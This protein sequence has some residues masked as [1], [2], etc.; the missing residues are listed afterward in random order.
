MTSNIKTLLFTDKYKPKSYSDLLTDE[1]TNREILT[2]MKSWD[3]IV[4]N[5]KFQIPKIPITQ[6]LTQIRSQNKKNIKTQN[7]KIE[8]KNTI[9]QIIEYYEVEYV[10]SKHKII[11]ISGPPG[12][13]KTTIAN[14]ISRQC[15]Y[16]PIIIN[17]S[18][19]RTYDKLITRIYDTTL[20][21]N[22]NLSKKKNKPTCLI[23]D[24]I[25]GISS[26]FVGKNSIKNI[27]DFIK[28]GKLNK[29]IFGRHK[30][31]VLN[32]FDNKIIKV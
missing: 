24:E 6:N 2:W 18:D 12:I 31:E 9:N 10:Q 28:N 4:F 23:L 27:I 15:G 29:A 21:N 19:E 32:D 30:K 1:K 20:I 16:E 17:S 3:E 8:K 14:I 13:G 26:D 22:L 25:D 5:K 7:S 11:L